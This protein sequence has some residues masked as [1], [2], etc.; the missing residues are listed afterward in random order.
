MC[1]AISFDSS[2]HLGIRDLNDVRSKWWEARNKWFDIG[3]E[4]NLAVGDLE[5]LQQKHRDDVAKCFT[6]MLKIWLR[7]NLRP[8]QSQL[9]AALRQG[10]VGFNRLAEDLEGENGLKRD[11]KVHQFMTN[12]SV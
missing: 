5:A 2:D 6:D 12:P 8:T 4:L 10:T 9:S 3:L 7:T 11:R 1:F